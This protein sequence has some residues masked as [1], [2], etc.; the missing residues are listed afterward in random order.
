MTVGKR[1]DPSQPLT[2]HDVAERLDRA[3]LRL[4]RIMWDVRVNHPELLGPVRSSRYF[5]NAAA[6]LAY[7]LGLDEWNIEPA[8]LRGVG[9]VRLNLG[10]ES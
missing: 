10:D 6:A 7:E 1:R 8:P 2:E 5:T 9:G 4:L 3:A